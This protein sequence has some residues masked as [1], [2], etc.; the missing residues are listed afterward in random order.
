M[1]AV[2]RMSVGVSLFFVISGYCIAASAAGHAKK[3]GSAWGFMG[4]RAWRIYPPYWAALLGFV[5]VVVALDAAGLGRLC[6]GPLGIDLDNPGSLSWGQWLGNL[7]LAETWRP[8][9]WGPRRDVY[10]SVAWSLCFEEQFYVICFLALWLA[11]GGSTGRSA[12]RRGR[13]WRSG[14]GSGGRAGW[15]L[16]AA[17]SRSSGTSSP[18]DWRS[19]TA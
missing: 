3:G 11:P 19:I 6:R 13:S 18:S 7:T 4:R 2:R 10:T 12:W 5:A 15:V 9:V 17:R 1:L 8:Y 16:S 14:S